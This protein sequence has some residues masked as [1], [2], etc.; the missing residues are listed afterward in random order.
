M[1]LYKDEAIYKMNINK[2]YLHLDYRRQSKLVSD[3]ECLFK[4]AWS[5]I[6]VIFIFL[7]I[8]QLSILWFYWDIALRSIQ[9]AVYFIKYHKKCS[10]VSF[11]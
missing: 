7:R 3:I 8:G 4:L 11:Y 9:P 2:N 6:L 5:I 1:W 10:N